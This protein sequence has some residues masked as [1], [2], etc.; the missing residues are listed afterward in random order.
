MPT[1][2]QKRNHQYFNA[3]QVMPYNEVSNFHPKSVK[4]SYNPGTAKTRPDAIIMNYFVSLC[5]KHCNTA[6]E[7]SKDYSHRG[8][9]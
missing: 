6:N 7:Q 5:K 2:C 8:R 3:L 1:S 9:Q 4:K